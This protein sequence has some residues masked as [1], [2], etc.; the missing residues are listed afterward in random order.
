MDEYYD[1]ANFNGDVDYLEV[2]QDGVMSN[3]NNTLL[4]PPGMRIK[5]Y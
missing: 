5:Y 2:D 3:G 1:F 4:M